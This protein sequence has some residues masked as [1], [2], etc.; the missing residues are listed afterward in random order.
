MNQAFRRAPGVPGIAVAGSAAAS[1]TFFE[2]ENF[3]GREFVVD[4]TV[5]N[6]GDTRFNDRARSAA[7][8][9][10]IWTRPDSTT[11]RRPMRGPG[12]TPSHVRQ[13]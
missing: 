7:A 3:A 2:G 6:F 5:N 13:Q 10:R 8:S 11:A 4:Q 9:W 1:I 12:L